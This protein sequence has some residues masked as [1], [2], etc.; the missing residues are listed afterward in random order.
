MLRQVPPY[1]VWVAVAI[2]VLIA[3][4]VVS[5]PAFWQKPNMVVVRKPGNRFLGQPQP[6]Q[7]FAAEDLPYALLSVSAYSYPAKDQLACSDVSAGLGEQWVQWLN[8]PD[9]TLK[10]EMDAVHL[11]AQVWENKSKRL[12]VVTFGGTVA[13]NL[14][15]W[16]ANTHWLHPFVKDEYTV[17]AHSFA[18]E[19]A[20]AMARTIEQS[21]QEY[22]RATIIATGHSLGA[23][24]AEKFAY[25]LPAD[26]FGI[27]RVSKVYAFDPSPVTT[28]L[29][30]ISQVRKENKTGLEI[31]RIYERGEILAILR[32]ITSL[33]H[34]PPSANPKVRQLRYNL[35]GDDRFGLTNPVASHSIQQLACRLREVAAG[36]DV[37]HSQE[38]GQ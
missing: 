9:K 38:T 23:G 33:I 20:K 10:A 12:I 5:R 24:L 27:P 36:S 15:D 8:F 16:K 26:T 13:T 31:D 1:W 6:A 7:A 14:M 25:S 30:T 18:P 22:D 17:V 4:V 19:F 34:K 21:G 2:I 32:S 3:A 35:F 29:N 28:Y 11:R 37:K